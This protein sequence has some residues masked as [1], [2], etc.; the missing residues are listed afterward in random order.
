MA[1]PQISPD[2]ICGLVFGITNLLLNLFLLWQ[3]R[4]RVLNERGKYASIANHENFN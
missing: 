2:F 1:A 4:Q 3:G